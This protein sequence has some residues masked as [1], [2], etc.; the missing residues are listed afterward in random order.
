MIL[1]HIKNLIFQNIQYKLIAL[2]IAA[3]LWYA[4][5]GEEVLELN[6]K[7]RVNLKV[8]PNFVVKG[9]SIRYKDATLSGPRALLG[10]FS[11]ES[12]DAYIPISVTKPS[13]LRFRIDKEFIRNWNRSI[14]LTV[15]DAYMSIDVDEKMQK[16]LLIKEN[17]SGMPADGYILEKTI[18]TPAKVL[19]TGAKSELAPLTQIM[20]E[21]IDVTGI[22]KSR[23][24]EASLVLL[25]RPVLNMS[26]SKV[27]IFLQIGEKKLN[28]HFGS[29]P[30]EVEGT[31]YVSRVMPRFISV[32]VQGTA[33]TLAQ[34]ETKSFRSFVEARGEEPGLYE[35]LVQVKIPPET[36]LVE[37]H[38][39]NITI[40][41][42]NKKKKL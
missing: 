35:K 8:P 39:E 13:T 23:S 32:T 22:Y 7:I 20:T 33:K 42:Y 25:P 16:S 26:L 10:D 11:S 17:I 1:D 37:I 9:G 34:L 40:E 38:P 18:I 41:I 36:A 27:S 31:E 15:H 29:I 5:Q 2:S 24:F 19:V 14:K 21:L 30:V 3:L 4:V 6:R 12:I 28:R